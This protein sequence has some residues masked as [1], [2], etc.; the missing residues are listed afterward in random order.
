VNRTFALTW[1]Y[2][3]PPL[4]SSA[5]LSQEDPDDEDLEELHE[6]IKAAD[7]TLLGRAKV[8]VVETKEEKMAKTNL[9][10]PLLSK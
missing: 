4:S 1:C 5:R 10:L 7:D 8:W 6:T 3:L 9:H 2:S